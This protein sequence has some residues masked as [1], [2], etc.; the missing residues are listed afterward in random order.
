MTFRTSIAAVQ[1]RRSYCVNNGAADFHPV[2]DKSAGETQQSMHTRARMR[3]AGMDLF[4]AAFAEQAPRA[5]VLAVVRQQAIVVFAEARAGA[6]HGLFG[7][8]LRE[9][10]RADGNGV[11]IGEGFERHFFDGAAMGGLRETCVV[12]D[13]A[14]TDVNAVM[15]VAA[16]LG[17]QMGTEGGFV[18]GTVEH[19]ISR[20]VSSRAVCTLFIARLL[21][22]AVHGFA[23]V[24]G[25][26]GQHCCQL[27]CIIRTRL[28]KPLIY[29]DISRQRGS[30]RWRCVGTHPTEFQ[31]DVLRDHHHFQLPEPAHR[32]LKMC[33]LPRLLQRRAVGSLP[34][35]TRVRARR[36][37][38]RVRFIPSP[39]RTHEKAHRLTT[40]WHS[41][42]TS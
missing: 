24:S 34:T 25:S 1:L 29:R 38:A 32:A 12:N 39:A 16:A 26:K 40:D 10:M 2:A 36:T 20:C 30:L 9:R 3:E 6:Q 37:H 5:E 7:G 14:A 35:S 19:H 15:F 33:W 42:C 17:D 18:A 4:A 41:P 31:A 23:L 13:L 21:E 27:F 28:L 22:V 8:V 11:T